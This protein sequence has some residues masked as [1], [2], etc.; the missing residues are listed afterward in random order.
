[1]LTTAGVEGRRTTAMAGNIKTKLAC[2]K[3]RERNDRGRWRTREFWLLS[4]SICL[5]TAMP[6][7]V[8]GQAHPD[9]AAAPV[10]TTYV[11]LAGNANALLIEP[12]KPSPK[13]RILAIN[14]HPANNNFEYFAG[15]QMVARGYRV[16][17]VN[18]YGAERTMEEYL[19]PL[20]AALRYARGV[21]GVKT[22]VLLGHS[23]GGPEL[24][25]Y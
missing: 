2:S 10:K 13:E 3:M 1:M 9:Q 22:V 6:P 17:E 7:T 8:L 24:S 23:G 16:L 11:R 14:T 25:Y 19:P 5:C 12:V 21:P 4:A 18:Y 20:G 15:R